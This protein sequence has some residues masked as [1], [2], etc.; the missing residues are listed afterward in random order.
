MS[1]PQF[2]KV[3]ILVVNRVIP[4]HV[5]LSHWKVEV[6]AYLIPDCIIGSNA[7]E[8]VWD[9]AGVCRSLTN[10]FWKLKFTYMVHGLHVRS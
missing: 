9:G 7:V 3:G 2:H 5:Q 6:Q 10:G 1:V 8:D 4:Y